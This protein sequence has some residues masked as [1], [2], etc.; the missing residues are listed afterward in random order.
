MKIKMSTWFDEEE[1]RTISTTLEDIGEE[2]LAA[3]LGEFLEIHENSGTGGAFTG[4]GSYFAGAYVMN[5]HG[6]N[7][8]KL[9][10]LSN[11]Y[12]LLHDYDEP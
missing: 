1:L 7:K 11:D 3:E 2:E 8:E 12:D 10:E 5:L 9:I 4:R 6:V